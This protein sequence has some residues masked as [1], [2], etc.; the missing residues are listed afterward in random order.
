MNTTK[1]HQRY[2]EGR[3][4]PRIQAT[5]PIRVEQGDKTIEAITYD[6]SPDG[7][8]VRCNRQ[9]AQILYSK[10]G[11]IPVKDR[12]LVD[13]TLELPA[14]RRGKKFSASCEVVYMIFLEPT[15]P[16]VENAAIGLRFS[17]IRGRSGKHLQRFLFKR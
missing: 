16:G 14:G 11:R 7:L 13:I 2:E 9:I 12:P 15:E 17:S 5:I 6:I 1:E 10:T 3:R 4:F 8:Q